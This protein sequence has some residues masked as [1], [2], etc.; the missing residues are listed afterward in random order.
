[1]MTVDKT[2]DKL[3]L[4]GIQ[5]ETLIGLLA[6]ERKARQSLVVDLVLA[7]DFAPAIARDQLETVVNYADVV[8][9]I[10]HF[11]SKRADN[12]LERFAHFLA[13]DLRQAFPLIQKATVRVA[14]PRY[15]G[16][17]GLDSIEVHVE[18]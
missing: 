5:V 10:R 1:M 9:H 14:K 2:T 17:L 7:L 3:V 15:A 18:R 6:E 4:K 11:A 13:L 16:P 8:Q 12:T